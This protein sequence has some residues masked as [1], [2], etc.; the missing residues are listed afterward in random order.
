MVNIQERVVI[1]YNRSK[2]MIS[3]ALALIVSLAWND[4]FRHYFKTHPKM[5][6]KAPWTYALIVTII[7]LV[8]IFIF[9]EDKSSKP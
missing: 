6:D 5:K 7:L 2:I 4:A 3:T 8:F 9:D 1:V